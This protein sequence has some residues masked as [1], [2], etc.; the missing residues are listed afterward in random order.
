MFAEKYFALSFCVKV[1]ER[2]VTFQ[3]YL[4]VE[5]V[6]FNLFKLPFNSVAFFKGSS[7]HNSQLPPHKFHVGLQ[8]LLRCK[9][10]FFKT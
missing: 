5:N 1:V 7:A 4:Y 10:S 9:G 6:M 2:I 3:V 8:A